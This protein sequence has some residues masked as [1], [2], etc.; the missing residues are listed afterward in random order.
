MSR[1]VCIVTI[2]SALC[3]LVCSCARVETA[4]VSDANIE[5]T[6]WWR[7]A[8]FGMFIHWGLY[9]VPAGEWKGQEVD[10][11]S[12]W[13]MF[14]HKIPVAEYEKLA[15]KFS[16]VKFDADEWVGLAKAAGMKY[17]V[18]TSKHHDGF[19]MYDSMVSDYDIVDRTPYGRDV[20]GALAKACRSSGIKFGCYYSIDRDWHEYDAG[21]NEHE[22]DNRW[23]WPDVSKK[24]FNKYL[25]QKAMPQVEEILRQY[26]PDIVWFDGIGMKTDEQNTRIVELVRKLQPTCLINS[27]LDTYKLPTEWGDYTSMDDNVVP[28]NYRGG[29]WEN[30]GTIGESYGYHKYDDDW[31][32]PGEII[33]ML[34]DIVSKGGNYLLN[35]G[36]K[37]DGTIPAEAVRT[38]LA[39]G[40]WMDKH[41]ES[42]Y[43]TSASPI[44]QPSWGRCTAKAGK[45][46]LHI[47][48]WP[49]DGQLVA[50]GVNSEVKRAYMLADPGKKGLGFVQSSN[51]D[52]VVRIGP[53]DVPEKS[54]DAFDTVVVLEVG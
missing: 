49:G 10:G 32:R 47:F 18:I 28:P 4:Y 17:M 33:E 31:K 46:Y 21:S 27:R 43:E 42:I 12:E 22:Q 25:A 1:T 48:D 44:G 14:H 40:K 5:R 9:A 52:V 3:L 38:L 15:D 35:V 6:Q 30:P 53:D 24:D 54:P 29:G 51:G 16:L 23:D 19:A 41:G 13:V 20:I 7:D 50:K 45:L 37:A 39:V 11:Y 26:K 34:V 8:K 2:F 36:P